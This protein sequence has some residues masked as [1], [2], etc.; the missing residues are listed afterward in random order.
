MALKNG[1]AEIDADIVENS[2]MGIVTKVNYGER[3]R[4][5]C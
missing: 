3:I 5:I 4:K 1:R 2:L